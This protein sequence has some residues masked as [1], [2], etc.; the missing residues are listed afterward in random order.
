[1]L[2][3]SLLSNRL[4]ILVNSLSDRKR[5]LCIL[6]AKF[7]CSLGRIGNCGKR[8]VEAIT[9]WNQ[10]HLTT[11]V[12]FPPTIHRYLLAE[13]RSNL[14]THQYPRPS[15]CSASL[16]AADGR[17]GIKAKNNR[18]Q[19]IGKRTWELEGAVGRWGAAG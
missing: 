10:P 18:E 4:V 13:L 2:A 17:R 6:L 11:V 5:F 12:P 15:R 16:R 14:Q 3:Q 19:I 8:A 9:A 7:T 1:L